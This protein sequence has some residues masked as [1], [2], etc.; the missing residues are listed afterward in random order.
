MSRGTTA[1]RV[2]VYVSL[3]LIGLC[4]LF[5]GYIVI[6]PEFDSAKTLAMGT[7]L[8]A[9]ISLATAIVG[10]NAASSIKRNSN[11]GNGR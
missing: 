6:A 2:L 9:L 1:D 4:V 7:I 5:G 8:G 3:A 10:V 11:G